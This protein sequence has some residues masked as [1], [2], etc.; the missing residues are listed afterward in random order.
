MVG[1]RAKVVCL[2]AA[3]MISLAGASAPAPLVKPCYKTFTQKGAAKF[4]RS[5]KGVL[6]PVYPYLAEYLVEKYQLARKEGIGIDIGSG[7]GDLVLELAKRTESMYWI[8]ADINPHYF[9]Y[10]F[11]SA[12]KAK[13]SHR[14][15]AVFADAQWLPFRDD[16]ADMFVSRGS[17][18]FWNDKNEA[19]AEILRVLK[20]GGV[21]FVGRGFPKNLPLEKA[22]AVRSGQGKGGPKYDK[23]K[24]EAELRKVMEAVG[25]KH[26]SIILPRTDQSK[27]NYGIWLA[28]TKPGGSAAK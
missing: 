14:V 17:L 24:T 10:F 25:V 11:Q 28:F 26:Y 12:R 20:P 7:P 13:L 16:Y 9:E 3:A 6:A 1:N 4:N 27:V 19:F 18:Q 22:Q 5:A 15:G 23:A 2:V 8:D 21:A